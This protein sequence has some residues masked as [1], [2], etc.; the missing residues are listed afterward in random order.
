VNTLMR[1]E[2]TLYSQSCCISNAD[3][4]TFT[5]SLTWRGEAAHCHVDFLMVS[6]VSHPVGERSL[7]LSPYGQDEYC[8]PFDLPQRRKCAAISLRM[9]TRFICVS[10]RARVFHSHLKSIICQR[11]QG[12]INARETP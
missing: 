7:R 12:G 10:A 4:T 5:Y 6:G 3:L 9:L 1:K 8:L 2:G 11:L